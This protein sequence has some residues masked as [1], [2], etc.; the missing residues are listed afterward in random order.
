MLLLLDRNRYAI[1]YEGRGVEGEGFAGRCV[2]ECM[3]RFTL[4]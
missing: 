2:G 3:G 4:R 1:G